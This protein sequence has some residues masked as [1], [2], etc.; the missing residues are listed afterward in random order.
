MGKSMNGPDW[1]DIGTYASAIGATSES[2][3][4]LLLDFDGSNVVPRW[5][6][7]AFT[8]P[9]SPYAMATHSGIGASALWPHRDHKTMEGAVFNLL[10]TLDGLL[11]REE[12]LD[13]TRGSA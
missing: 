1:D 5:R 9:K 8:T 13:I 2:F 6:V 12:F 11:A 10:A 4:C 3:V 7:T